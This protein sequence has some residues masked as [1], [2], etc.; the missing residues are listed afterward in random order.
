MSQEQIPQLGGA[1]EADLDAAF[2]KIA[3]EVE[4]S[5]KSL[6]GA[7]AVE[8]FRLHWLGRKQGRLKAIGDAW[9][10]AAPPEARRLIGQ[11]FNQLK[12]EI[13]GKLEA[14]SRGGVSASQLAAESIE[15]RP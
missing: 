15:G 1:S 12:E 14:A 10:K 2:G 5:A 13:E 6:S 9:L 4:H 3:A 8:Q 7:E 11:R